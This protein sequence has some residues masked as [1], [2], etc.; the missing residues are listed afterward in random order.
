M[1]NKLTK[2]DWQTLNDLEFDQDIFEKEYDSDLYMFV[3]CAG[4]IKQ[5][6]YEDG[7]KLG[8]VTLKEHDEFFKPINALL[9]KLKPC[10]LGYMP[11]DEFPMKQQDWLVDLLQSETETDHGRPINDY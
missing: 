8:E 2:Q 11:G 9:N 6:D 4:Q 3:L 5:E 7:I 1:I 10:P